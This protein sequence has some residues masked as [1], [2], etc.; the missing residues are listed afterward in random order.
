MKNSLTI[1]VSGAK[2]LKEQRLTLKALV[3]NLNGEN[4]LKGCPVTLNMF[5]YVNLGDNQAEYD[6]F[7]QHKTDIVIFLIEGG[8]GERPGK[9]SCWLPSS[10]RK[11][12]HRRCTSS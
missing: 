3:N 10:S 9:N 8:L 12:A 11:R 6:D 1:F 2:R 5:S 4:R 7:I